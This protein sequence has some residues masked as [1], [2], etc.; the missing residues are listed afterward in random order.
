M[1]KSAFRPRQSANKAAQL[2]AIER[3]KLQEEAS[4]RTAKKLSSVYD[5]GMRHGMKQC[6]GLAV[7]MIA[8]ACVL[9]MRDAGCQPELIQRVIDSIHAYSAPIADADITIDELH[10]SVDAFCAKHGVTVERHNGAIGIIVE[11]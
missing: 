11:A 6:I 5:D 9:S 7:D 2:T 1:A 8:A 3:H 10:S 4:R